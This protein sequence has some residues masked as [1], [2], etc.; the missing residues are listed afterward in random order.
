MCLIFWDFNGNI[1][2][3]AIAI[4]MGR[5]SHGKRAV[6]LD[7]ELLAYVEGAPCCFYRNIKLD[8]GCGLEVF[9]WDPC[10]KCIAAQGKILFLLPT[11]E[12]IFGSGSCLREILFADSTNP[13]DRGNA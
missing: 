11:C 3:L 1:F 12:L 7:L 5:A 2:R 8:A 6:L 13:A 10:G 4:E 9:Q